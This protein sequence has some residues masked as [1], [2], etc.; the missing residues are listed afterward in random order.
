M[1]LVTRVL[2]LLFTLSQLAQA[3]TS[4]VTP[5]DNL[6]A[7]IG[8][9]QPG[10]TL[11]LA[12][13]T[14]RQVLH[15]LYGTAWPRGTPSQPITI[16]GAPGATVVLQL[17]AGTPTQ[18][19]IYVQNGAWLTF[20]NLTLDA[21][22]LTL[23]ASSGGNGFRFENSVGLRVQNSTVRGGNR[24]FMC[25][26]VEGQRL[27]LVGNVFQNCAYGVYASGH[28]NLIES[29]DISQ[30]AGYGVHQY[31]GTPA[32]GQA[33]PPQDNNVIRNN[34][35]HEFS[36]VAEI[37][38]TGGGVVTAGGTNNQ[39][40][41]NHIYN[42][43]HGLGIQIY[44]TA[45]NAQVYNNVIEDV[46]GPCIDNQNGNPGAQI[47]DNVCRKTGQGVV[48]NGVGALVA[49]NQMAPDATTTGTTARCGGG[50]PAPRPA[51][52]HLRAVPR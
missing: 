16:A 9:L 5:A 38:Q 46:G 39:V 33:P 18:D 3:S 51:P 7:A 1:R 14:Y 34:C 48:N 29:N 22:N 36:Q 50:R 19:M 42:G 24:Y 28:D 8:R 31:Q 43:P 20:D 21:S 49:N 32:S 47:H 45:R 12:S 13:G 17:P 27:A 11:L 52:T 41:G 2:C 25:T 15:S 35:I 26:L 6:S 10:D 40:Y 23:T 4:T 37:V 44:G 30:T